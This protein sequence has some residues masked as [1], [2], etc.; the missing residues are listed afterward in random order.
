MASWSPALQWGLVALATWRVCHLL[1]EEDGPADLVVRLRMRLG[2][3][4]AGRAMD[5][6]YCLSLW[7]AAP[8]ALL[9]VNDVVG[10]V[11]VWLS[12]SGA[13]CLLERLSTRRD[14]EK[15]DDA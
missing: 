8:L 1:A 5:C 15:G 14:A 2:N 11:L 7:M 3:S 12:A 9:I 6:F 13:A 4:A 10:F